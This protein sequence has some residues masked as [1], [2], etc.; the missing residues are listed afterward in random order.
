MELLQVVE[1]L[2]LAHELHHRR[3]EGVRGAGRVRVRHLHLVLEPRVEE[4]RPALGLGQSPFGEELRVE[5]EPERA[6]VDADGPVLRLLGLAHGPLVELHEL[7]RLVLEC[8]PLLRRLEVWV[9]G[10]A[11]PDVTLRVRGLGLDLRVVLT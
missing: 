6:G 9:A 1:A 5:A 4:V 3:Q 8:Q 11:P 10:A 2:V 7:R